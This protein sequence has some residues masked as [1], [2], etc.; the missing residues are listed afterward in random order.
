MLVPKKFEYEKLIRGRYPTGYISELSYESRKNLTQLFRSLIE[1]EIESEQK[2]KLLNS[3]IGFSSY[4]N[5]E[6]VKGRFKSAI[7]KSDVC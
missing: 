2:R 1:G 3:S 5:F 4:E 7:L 6:I